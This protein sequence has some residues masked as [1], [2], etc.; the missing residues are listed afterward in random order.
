LLTDY[1]ICGSIG[2]Q[3]AGDLRRRG[4]KKI[5]PRLG[6]HSER[7]LSRQ[8]EDNYKYDAAGNLI[9][10]KAA[11]ITTD[12]TWSVYGKLLTI[13]SK[14][15]SYQYDAAGNR[16][17]KTVGSTSTWYVRDAQGNILA[18]YSGEN[19]ALQEQDMYGSSRL[20]IIPNPAALSETSQYLD[21]LGSGTLFTFTR[22]K[23]LFELTN[24]LGN[25]L[26]TVS[27]KKFGTPTTGIPSQISYYSADVKSAQDYYPFGMEMPGRQFNSSGYSYGF[28]GQ[29]KSLDIGNNL[30][31]AQFWEYD[32]RSGRRWNLDPKPTFGISE[33]STFN[34]SP[35]WFSDILGDT[36]IK[37]PGGGMMDIGDFKFE[38]FSGTIQQVGNK[39]IQPAKGALKSFTVTGENV[40]NK[41]ARFVAVFD[42]ES[43]DFQGYAWDKDT[44]YSYGDFINDAR[45]D[46]ADQYAHAGDI[47]YQHYNSPGEANASLLSLTATVLLPNP[48]FKSATTAAN[49]ANEGRQFTKSSLRFGQQMHRAY[50]VGANG[51][52]EFRLPSGRR[53]DFLDI[54]NGVIYELKPYNPRAILQGQKQLQMYKQELETLPRFQDIQWKTVLDTY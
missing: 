9:Q 13:P 11:G 31:T 5:Y 41:S 45:K 39:K 18:T 48:I 21:H 22:G 33:Y 54:E 44:K 24:H 23:K 29:M 8:D 14:S 19:M 17:G 51:I 52:K 46:L 30:Y 47:L 10:D 16:I 15:I 38:T 4:S 1:R 7:E 50:K 6:S 34:G 36:S 25:V 3:K 26:A 43:G 27:D 28:N 20:G 49:A 32:S 40:D 12:M 42:K 53:I 37:T 2:D 35:I